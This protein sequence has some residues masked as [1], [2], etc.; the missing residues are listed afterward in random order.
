MFSL[1]TSITLSLWAPWPGLPPCFRR[2]LVDVEG[3]EGSSVVLHCELT[4]PSASVEWRR[5]EEPLW[6]G[7]KYQMKM[8]E[9]QVELRIVELAAEDGGE[10]S[11]VC[12]EHMTTARLGV[13]GE[14]DGSSFMKLRLKVN[15]GVL[16]ESMKHRIKKSISGQS[17]RISKST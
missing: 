2:P 6:E 5:E 4:K 17:V 15:A 12:G 3:T 13:N 9:L 7:G 10:Y 1:V 11:C 16:L 14:W 8:K